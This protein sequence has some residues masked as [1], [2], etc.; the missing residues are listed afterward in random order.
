MVL[1]SREFKAKFYF[2]LVVKALHPLA[3]NLHRIIRCRD[4]WQHSFQW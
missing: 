1:A 4:G 2:G 3:Q